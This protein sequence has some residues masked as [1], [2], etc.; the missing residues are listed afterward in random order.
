MRKLSGAKHRTLPPRYWILDGGGRREEV[1]Y[2]SRLKGGARQKVVRNIAPYP[3]NELTGLT[4]KE[5]RRAGMLFRIDSYASE[6]NYVVYS[7]IICKLGK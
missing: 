4:R 5:P 2:R 3:G 1:C 6:Q 7:E